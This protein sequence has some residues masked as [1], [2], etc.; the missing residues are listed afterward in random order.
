MGAVDVYR[1]P[2]RPQLTLQTQSLSIQE[3]MNV[4]AMTNRKST[5]DDKQVTE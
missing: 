1:N 3:L 4:D 2:A 5:H